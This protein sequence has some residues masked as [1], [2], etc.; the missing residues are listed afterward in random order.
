MNEPIQAIIFDVGGVLV[1]THDQSGR[2][3]WEERLGLAP[4]QLEAI[5]LNSEMGHRAQRGEISDDEL[6]AWVSQRFSL[7]DEL[8]A[9]RPDFWRGD[10]VDQGLV[11]LV[12]RLNRRYQTAIISNA[13]D[14]LLTTLEDYQLLVE[15]DLVVGSAYEGLMKPAPAIFETTLIRLGRVAAETVFIDDAP[16][17]IAGAQAVGLQTILFTPALDLAAELAALG[18]RTD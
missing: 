4:G 7:G 13:T 16:A 18:V 6:W 5:V 14:A 15:F 10:A 1:R 9:F 12:G 8:D 3:V 2:R 11:A 17:N